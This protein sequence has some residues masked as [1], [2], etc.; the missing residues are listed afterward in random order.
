[1]NKAIITSGR[2]AEEAIHKCLEKLTGKKNPETSR[3]GRVR[4]WLKWWDENAGKIVRG[5]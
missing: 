4:F 3:E 5:K 1:M 2:A